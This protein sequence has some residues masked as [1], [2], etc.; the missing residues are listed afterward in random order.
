MAE[1]TGVLEVVLGPG[2]L[3][4]GDRNTRIRT[5]LGSCVAITLW[6]PVAFIGGMCHY[7]N[8]SRGGGNPSRGG[9][10]NPG[11]G[12]GVNPGRA[13]D[14]RPDELSG[15]YADE[16]MLMMLDRMRAAGTRPCEY[17]VKM[18][19]AGAQFPYVPGGPADVPGRNIEAGLRL[20]AEHGITP[21]TT[22]LGGTGH[23]QVVLELWSGDVWLRHVART[24][25]LRAG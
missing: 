13:E 6:H 2:D 7:V 10:A 18:F 25:E 19:G 16:A 1:R 21:V 8:P 24:E 5:L 22:H 20:L 4:F 11:R 12:G 3:Y 14:V 9:G 15:R 17:Q 23:R